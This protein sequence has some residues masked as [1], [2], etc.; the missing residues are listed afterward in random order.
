LGISD[1]VSEDSY[2]LEDY[3]ELG[4][5]G[6]I[7]ISQTNQSVGSAP[8]VDTSGLTI[9]EWLAS[10][11]TLSYNYEQVVSSRGYYL[12]EQGHI[13]NQSVRLQDN[14]FYQAFSYLIETT[15][16]ISEY[17]SLLKI[18]HPAGTKRFSSL[19]K[20]GEIS[21]DIT[22]ERDIASDIFY[23]Y[24]NVAASEDVSVVIT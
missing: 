16:D 15:K 13:S 8:S 2:F 24:D 4:Y 7:V 5:S 14:Y 3:V 1:G 19:S 22:S 11:A 6:A 21:F 20:I 23:I 10:R 9:T 12:N 18:T 17:S